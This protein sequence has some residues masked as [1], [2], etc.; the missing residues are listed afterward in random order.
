MPERAA[1]GARALHGGTVIDSSRAS[2]TAELPPPTTATS[3]RGKTTPSQCGAVA[4]AGQ[5]VLLRQ[6]DASAGPIPWRAQRSGQGPAPPSACSS[7]TRPVSCAAADVSSRKMAPAQLRTRFHI[8]SQCGPVDAVHKTGVIFNALRLRH[9]PAGAEPLEKRARPARRGRHRGPPCSLP[10]RLRPRPCHSISCFAQ[11]RRNSSSSAGVFAPGRAPEQPAGAEPAAASGRS[12]RQTAPASSGW[13]STST[14]PMRSSGRASA[15]AS[16]TGASARH[17]PH[18]TR[19]RGLRAPAPRP[20]GPPAR[21]FL[22]SK[23]KS[24]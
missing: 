21:N 13:A 14:F 15:S 12:A 19:Q 17:G 11:L 23:V 9:L 18:H 4:H 6:P 8:R 20:A 24:A 10:A 22:P 16:S 1:A 3:F 7:F 2:L 5:L